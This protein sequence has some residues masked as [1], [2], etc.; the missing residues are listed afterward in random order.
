MKTALSNIKIL[1]FTT[2][3]PGPYAT[4]M[5][6][7]MGADVLK[8]SSPSKLDLVLEKE[9]FFE[10]TNKSANL[11]WL[12]RN[13]KTM[14]LNLKTKEAIEIVKELVKE[15][16]VLIE[17]FRPGVM[18]DLG[19]SYNDLKKINPSL[20]YCSISSYGQTGPMS[21]RAGHDI[22]FLAKSGIMSLSGKKQTGPV[23]TN[24][25]IGDLAIGANH[26]I[27]GILAAINYRNLT[28]EGQY[29]DISML[30]GLIPYNTFDGAGYL[31]DEQIP[32][33][34]EG[35]LNGGCAYD[36]YRTLDGRYLS[37][38]SLEPKFWKAFCEA[39]ERPEFINKTVWPEDVKDLKDE[40]SKT[41]SSKTLSE[42]NEIFK[43]K[44]CCVEPVQNLR[45]ALIEDEHIKSR[46]LVI[47]MPVE[48]KKVKQ[49]SMPIK[50]SKSKP[51][52]KYVGKKIGEDTNSIMKSLGYSD[53]EIKDL[54]NKDVFK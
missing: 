47:E 19:L 35:M 28:G 18:K 24:T 9:P 39:I 25:Q 43:D 5:M 48:D 23:L 27:I 53:K 10:D 49:F 46:E 3:L 45:E 4:L 40:I 54:K 14:A 2:L 1:D 7:D 15:Y 20:I 21:K 22:N 8:I 32:Q 12:N 29:I 41:I 16:D 30:D 50:F 13:K 17:Q 31:V 6:A 33:R 38:G 26:A 44:D 42:W 34:E 37:V 11:L 36:F 51:E 52:Y